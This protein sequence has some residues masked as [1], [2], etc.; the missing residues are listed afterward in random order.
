MSV[1]MVWKHPGSP[2]KK[3]FRRT[4]PVGKLMLTV[5][6]DRRGPLL[7][8]FMTRGATIKADSYCGTLASL[9][10]AIRKKRPGILVDNVV[11]LH[12]NARPHV[13]N[14]LINALWNVSFM[15]TL[16]PLLLQR[17]LSHLNIKP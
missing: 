10:A 15:L 13:A 9:R 5:F 6:W 12:D 1:G 3:K 2:A 14:S 17:Q 11:L 7:L 16:N 8:D 4:P